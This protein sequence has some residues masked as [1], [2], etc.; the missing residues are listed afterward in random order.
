VSV[1]LPLVV[2]PPDLSFKP[3]AG[4]FAP[5]ESPVG[6]SFRA[7]RFP[8]GSA[9][10]PDDF[11]AAQALVSRVRIPGG[12]QEIWDA[13]A[14]AWRPAAGLDQTALAG[15][16]LLPPKAGDGPWA[17]MLVAAGQADA[18][19]APQIEAATAH[20]P[21]YRVRGLFRAH[22]GTVDAVGLGPES[23]P[24]EFASAVAA[25]RFGAELTPAPESATRVRIVLRNGA[26]QAVGALD[27]DASGGNAVLTLATFDAAGSPRA[28][29]SIQADGSIRLAPLLPNRVIVAGDLETEHIFY[30]RGAD[31]TGQAKV[32]L[33]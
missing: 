32:P 5:L 11:A 21:F 10:T 8:D 33:A 17:G 29:V 28:S 9:M 26:A 23:P 13:S 27:I 6:V 7:V 25:A 24:I 14:K 15:V 12:G 18:T 30:L 16:P 3:I 20:Y 4:M 1:L 31:P 22:R 2:P 19:G